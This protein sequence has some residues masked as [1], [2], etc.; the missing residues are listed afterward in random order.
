[1]KYLPLAL[2][3]FLAGCPASTSKWNSP[4]RI[5]G[6]S[7]VLMPDQKS[8]QEKCRHEMNSEPD[9]MTGLAHYDTWRT[10][11]CANVEK[12]VIVTT[13][14]AKLL[15]HEFGHMWDRWCGRDYERGR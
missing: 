5:D 8:V 7:V 2:L 10:D 11:A 6:I 4:C 1:M 15:L 9:T 13:P 3:T 12:K 14:S